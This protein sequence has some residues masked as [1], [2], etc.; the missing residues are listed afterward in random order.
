MTTSSE[1]EV[2][3]ERRRQKWP[4]EVERVRGM[5]GVASY[6]TLSAMSI[7]DQKDTSTSITM[8]RAIPTKTFP[9]LLMQHFS[10]MLYLVL[11]VIQ[12]LTPS[13]FMSRPQQARLPPP[14]I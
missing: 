2:T 14:A 10:L 7:R 8:L 12:I 1:K 5:P 9:K 6:R 3:N 4:S 13:I 11:L